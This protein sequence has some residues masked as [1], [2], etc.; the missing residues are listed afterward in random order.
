MSDGLQALS[1]QMRPVDALSAAGLGQLAGLVIPLQGVLDRL[2]GNAS[3][4]HSFVDAW[5]SV[6]QRIA[7]I[8]QQF[9]QSVTTGTAE[10]RGASADKYRQ[11]ADDF[12][13]SL[14]QFAAA[15][16]AAANTAKTTAEAVAAGRSSANDLITDLVQRLIS[17]VR[18]LMA[19][20]GGMTPTV[21][22]QAGQL[23]SSFAKPVATVER[24]VGT[25]VSNAAKPLGEL[26]TMV[27]AI[28]RL[29]D[30]Y[31]GNS[32]QVIRTRS[33]SA[34][35]AQAFSDPAT[36]FH[37]PRKPEHLAHD[38]AHVVQQRGGVAVEPPVRQEPGKTRDEPKTRGLLAHELAHPVQQRSG[39]P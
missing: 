24:Q 12:A 37:G 6:S 11:R 32:A 38:L 30:S 1:A 27:N 17:L 13:K 5:N 15:A 26:L 16:A 7:Q 21:L 29:W 4:V 23:V 35:G 22:A 31:A 28:T 10:W 20:E 18:Q 19:A 34:M 3:A 2:A 39:K 9:G 8:Q 25:T 36:N 33:A 14:A